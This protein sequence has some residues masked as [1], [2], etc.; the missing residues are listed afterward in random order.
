M[1]RANAALYHLDE[2]TELV[3]EDGKPCDATCIRGQTQQVIKHAAKAILESYTKLGLSKCH[4]A[5]PPPHIS[6]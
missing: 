5:T 1:R 6:S 2:D 3:D 4:G